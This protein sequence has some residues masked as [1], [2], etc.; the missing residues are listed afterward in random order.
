[1]LFL[2]KKT[3]RRGDHMFENNK[4]KSE[5][6]DEIISSGKKNAIT[7]GIIGVISSAIIVGIVLAISKKNKIVKPKIILPEEREVPQVNQVKEAEETAARLRREF[8]QIY[9]IPNSKETIMNFGFGCLA[10]MKI[11]ENGEKERYQGIRVNGSL[12]FIDVINGK[13]DGFI[14]KDSLDDAKELVANATNKALEETDGKGYS[15]TE[16]AVESMLKIL[17]GSEKD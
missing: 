6:N 15:S 5:I 3:I 7:F 14:I 11:G 9:A 8:K 13:A 17:H 16:E 12:G 10:I 2:L 4:I 1:M